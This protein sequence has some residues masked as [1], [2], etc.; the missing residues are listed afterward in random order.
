MAKDDR[1]L[2]V[3]HRLIVQTIDKLLTGEL[4][5]NRLMILT[6]PGSAK[7]T[8]TSKLLPAWFPN[9]E[10]FPKDLI[11]ACSHSFK[12]VEGFGREARDTVD[13]EQAV[14]GITLSDTAAAASDWR[15][16]RNGGYFCGGVGSGITGHRAKLGLID[17]YCSSEEEALNMDMLDKHWSWYWNDFWPRLI[18]NESFQII[19]AN[20]RH[21]R[22]LV[23]R[24]IEK[25]EHKW[26]II[27]LPFFAE[28][29]DPLGRPAAPISLLD[30]EA[31][32]PEN[33]QR[34][35][36][37]IIATRLWPE[38]FSEEKAEEVLDLPDESTKA[39]LWQQ[40]PIVQGGDLFKASD[41]VEYDAKDMPKEE[42]LIIYAG[43]DW[44]LRDKN[45]NDRTFHVFGGMDTNGLL[46]ILPDWFWD[47][48]DTLKG[49]EAMFKMAQRR[50]PLLWGQGRENI[51]G[52]IGPFIY[53]EMY[54]RNVYVPI[55][56]FSE[57]KNKVA[58]VQPFLARCKAKKVMFPR[59]APGWAEMKKE[60]L[61]FPN[62]TH[63][64]V[65]DGLAKLG[66]ILNKMVAPNV[67]AAEKTVEQVIEELS[68]PITLDWL[69]R[70]SSK[71]MARFDGR[72]NLLEV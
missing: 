29:N 63:D 26:H 53:K 19:I 50:S 17:D 43:S 24:L 66:H 46:W 45:R 15:T 33:L 6:P 20:R 60:L 72:G 47:R 42:S 9:P 56:E 69:E 62:Y 38:W 57:S 28:E 49:V 35:R 67:A 70:S 30:G 51:T 64:D 55:E 7:S 65:P 4:G 2:A 21:P 52:S 32:T 44:A 12:L 23:G 40:S 39:G 13:K 59:F 27:K 71:R 54:E 31:M 10:K 16:N 41:L 37:E 11:L 1:T 5:K 25:E 34:I 14:L 68:K 48:C 22:D 8:Y 58:K 36:K 18:P 3:H 61:G